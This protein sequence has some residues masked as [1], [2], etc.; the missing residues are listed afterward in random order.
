MVKC[1]R[2]CSNQRVLFMPD[3]TFGNY[4]WD[5]DKNLKNIKKHNL[6]FLDVIGIF[7]Q[8]GYKSPEYESVGGEVRFF[9]VGLLGNKETTVV[10]TMRSHHI[11]IISTRAASEE[12]RHAYRNR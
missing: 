6:S 2:Y 12:E 10:C 11:R 9:V 3:V 8:D 4:E 5:A 1:L 7:G